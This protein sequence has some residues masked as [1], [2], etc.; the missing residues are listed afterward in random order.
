MWRHCAFD[1]SPLVFAPAIWASCNHTISTNFHSSVRAFFT[2]P[3]GQL[4]IPG[5]GQEGDGCAARRSPKCTAGE[6]RAEWRT[7]E[8]KVFI[9]PFG[10]RRGIL[11]A[12]FGNSASE[13]TELLDLS[14]NPVSCGLCT[15]GQTNG[16]ARS[17]MTGR[18]KMAAKCWVFR[19]VISLRLCF[20]T[21]SCNNWW[22]TERG[23][24]QICRQGF[25]R[26]D[27]TTSQPSVNVILIFVQWWKAALILISSC[28][29]NF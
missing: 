24:I 6:Y 25:C 21:Y 9:I 19:L 12:G 7:N 27:S 26:F 2:K 28:I 16:L 22:V 1:A 15:K 5:Y 17:H 3:T 14:S 20:C 18:Q 29:L 4:S 10:G 13:C 23:A 11:T 8:S